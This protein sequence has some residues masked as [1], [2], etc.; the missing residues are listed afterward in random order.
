MATGVEGPASS[1]PGEDVW[2]GELAELLPAITTVRS[3]WPRRAGGV[4]L[5]RRG[6]GLVVVKALAHKRGRRRIQ[7]GA[8]RRETAML[9]AAQG[10]HVVRLEEV[11]IGTWFT[12]L[13]MEHLPLSTLRGRLGEPWSGVDLVA[14]GLGVTAALARLHGAGLLFND[15]KPRNVGIGTTTGPGAAGKQVVKLIDFG[16]ART[17]AETRARHCLCGT[18]DYAPPEAWGPGLMGTTSDVWA[19]GRSWHLLASGHYF[20][21]VESFRQLLRAGRA[22]LPPVAR[23]S[24]SPLPPGLA[25]LIDAALDPIPERR[26]TDGRELHAC[27]Q[28]IARD[29]WGEALADLSRFA[30]A[31][32]EGAPVTSPTE[33]PP[34]ASCGAQPACGARQVGQLPFPGSWWSSSKARSQAAKG[35]PPLTNTTSPSAVL[36]R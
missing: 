20:E 19:W 8:A 7:R 23:V 11:A 34:S 12:F 24:R 18:V 16:H 4:L 26:P 36:W 14:A 35:V 25:T 29:E 31:P 32:L 9:Q 13:V 15:F 10:A 1:A 30:M 28:A 2:R 3:L 6:E 27:L 21:R 17:L 22:P 5:A 33:A